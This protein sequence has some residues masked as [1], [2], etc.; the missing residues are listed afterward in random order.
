LKEEINYLTPFLAKVR[1]PSKLTREEAQRVRDACLKALKER[2]L[3]RSNIIQE[4]LNEE[5]QKLA[6]KQ[7]QFQRSQ[8]EGDMSGEEEFEHYSTEAMF[9]IQILE[10]R[11]RSH[12]EMALRKFMDMDNRLTNDPRLSILRML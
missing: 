9:R 8:R 10:E 5:N 2:L 11:L 1:D 3:E 4:R 6:R 7:E 12:E